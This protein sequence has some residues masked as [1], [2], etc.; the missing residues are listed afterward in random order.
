MSHSILETHFAD[1]TQAHDLQSDGR[2]IA[3]KRDDGM[4]AVRSQE[5]FVK[6]AAK[7][8]KLHAQ[9]PDTLVPLLPKQAAPVPAP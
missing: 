4:R 2:Y 8:A 6:D 7:R 3:A 9:S 1:N 5:A